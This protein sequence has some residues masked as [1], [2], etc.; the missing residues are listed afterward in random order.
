MIDTIR[1]LSEYLA[2]IIDF[3][4]AKGLRQPLAAILRLCC[5]ARLSGAK[6]PNGMAQWWEHR[7]DQA[8]LLAR[9]GFTRPYGP[10][11]ST[12]YRVLSQIPFQELTDQVGQW[13]EEH[14][15]Q[16][17]PQAADE[18]EGVAMDGKTL[19]GSQQQGAADTHLL[20]AVSH[21]LGVTLGQVAVPDKTNEIGAAPDF[22]AKLVIEGRVFTMDALLT[23]REIAQ[24]LID[25]KGDYLMLVKDN[26]PS[27]RMD[28]VML[29]TGSDPPLFI[30][31]E[32]TTL[33][34]SRGRVEVRTLQTSSALNDY[35]NW[36]GVQQVFRVD[37]RTTIR[38][39]G[40]VRTETVYGL[41]SLSARRAAAKM[42][43]RLTRGQ[44]TIENRSP[45]I[46]DVVF[47]EDQSQIHI[48]GLPHVL[49]TLRNVAVGLIRLYRF[50]GV[51]QTLDFFAA[52]P[53][54]ALAAFGC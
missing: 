23:Q 47:R 8:T 41:T 35:V 33:E 29:F 21:R 2:K 31:D 9:L 12:L 45:W 50:R 38:K 44:W 6:N 54:K 17:V 28:L 51:S 46:R 3:R 15:S 7:R 5:V 34:K 14:I 32:A 39:T 42:L 40:H 37:R 49:A 20:S 48:G 13:A 27:L 24:Y 52:H 22:W 43:L 36:P 53:F 4:Q 10:S 1:P 11:K 19:R 16:A 25:R 26:Q 30:E 18:L